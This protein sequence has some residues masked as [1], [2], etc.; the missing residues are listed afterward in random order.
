MIQKLS[1]V[2]EFYNPTQQISAYGFG[3]VGYPD[4]THLKAKEQGSCFLFNSI[5]PEYSKI[6]STENLM[7]DYGKVKK[8]FEE[9][10]N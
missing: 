7:R 8:Y 2:L 3:G 1:E 6:S 10:P 5:N 4:K 9:N